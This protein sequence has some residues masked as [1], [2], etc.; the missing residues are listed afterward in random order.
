VAEALIYAASRPGIPI[1]DF[2][3]NN[4]AAMDS[5]RADAATAAAGA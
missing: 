3:A 5:I 1:P 4:K 2:F